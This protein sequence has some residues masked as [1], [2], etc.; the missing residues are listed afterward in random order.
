MKRENLII[1]DSQQVSVRLL[2]SHMPELER[3]QQNVVCQIV[4]LKLERE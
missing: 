1:H 3:E 2:D 4:V